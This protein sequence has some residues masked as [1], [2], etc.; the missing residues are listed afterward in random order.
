[1]ALSS[2]T[3]SELDTF[4]NELATLLGSTTGNTPDCWQAAEHVDAHRLLWPKV[5]IDMEQSDE[6][7]AMVN[8]AY[9]IRSSAGLPE[10]LIWLGS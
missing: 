5:V 2:A 10:E 7:R 4:W 6:R 1:M 3:T 8:A 9:C